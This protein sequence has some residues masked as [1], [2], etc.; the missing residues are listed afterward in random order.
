MRRRLRKRRRQGRRMK[1]YEALLLDVDGTLLDF[2]KTERY[3]LAHTFQKFSINFS[4][5]M[6]KRYREINHELW[7]SYE[8]G[9]IE[10][11]LIFSSRF[12]NLFRELAVDAD[13]IAFEKEYQSC[14][15][16]T[17]F[18]MEDCMDVLGRLKK[19]YRLYIVTNGVA[20]TQR[21]KL[22]LT[23]IDRIVDGVFISEEIG[24]QKPQKAFFD[25]CA[26]HIEGYDRDRVLIV[27]DSLTSDIRGGIN[28]GID[29]CYFRGKK[30]ADI[31]DGV[32]VTYE[33]DS[34]LQLA[35]LL[36]V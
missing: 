32:S 2:E 30:S 18:Y 14:L 36:D 16:H 9:E 25:Y 10:K 17:W 34:L 12:V 33:V 13:G 4:G 27:G 21:T 23:G 35:E 7:E 22:A 19:K 3:A 8:R 15:A 11:S 28:A 31:T 24:V 5:T 6:E 1:T 29:T 26:A 20:S